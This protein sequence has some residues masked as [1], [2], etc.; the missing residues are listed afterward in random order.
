MQAVTHLVG[1]ADET[2]ELDENDVYVHALQSTAATYH[3][4]RGLDSLPPKRLMGW[5][6]L[7]TAKNDVASSG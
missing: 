3:V 7:E 1:A 4:A 2:S 5:A 6:S